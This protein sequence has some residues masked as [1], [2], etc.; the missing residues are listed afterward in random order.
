VS[1]ISLA[2]VLRSQPSFLPT[3]IISFSPHLHLNMHSILQRHPRYVLFSGFL[4]LS[5]F[6]LLA[7]QRAAPPTQFYGVESVYEEPLESR[8]NLAERIYQKTIKARK[9]LIRKFG[10]TPEKISL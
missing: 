10:P 4:L 3:S 5:T 6:L 1:V 2:D 9:D 7:S 8:L